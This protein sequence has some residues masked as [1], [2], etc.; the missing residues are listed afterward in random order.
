MFI[1]E[2]IVA[3]IFRLFNFGL[4]IAL[5]AYAFKQYVLPGIF[6]AMAKTESEREFLLDQQ[7]LFGQRQIEL[8][9]LIEQ[10]AVQ[11]EHFKK[12][13]DEWKRV[14][15]AERLV[16]KKE[17]EIR[18]TDIEKKQNKK[19][20]WRKKIL[21]QHFVADQ[22]ATDLQ[23]SLSKHFENEDAGVHYLEKIV[24]S[25]NERVL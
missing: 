7:R 15:E 16:E 22:V 9:Q 3:I 18:L 4:I 10:D 11:C 6:I 12:K 19:I 25:M 23:T 21:V 8:D 13:V 14:I 2:A 20:E 5:G 24:H 17:L 1:S